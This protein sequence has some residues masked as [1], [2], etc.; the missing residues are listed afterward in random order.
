MKAAHRPA[1]GTA[2]DFLLS[3]A[4]AEIVAA[5]R[6]L[7]PLALL[8]SAALDLLPVGVYV[9][10]ADGYI[11]RANSAARRLW[12][13]DIGAPEPVQRFCGCFRL[14]TI[15]GKFIPPH[16]TPMARAIRDG[17]AFD[18]V[19]A[20][21]ENPDGRRWIAS[22]TVQPLRD[23][24]GR[25]LGAVN[26]FQDVTAQFERREAL[27]RQQKSVNL[28]MIASRMGTW[29]YTMADN[30]CLYDENAQQLYGLTS[31]RFLHDAQGVKEKFHPDDLEDMW[32]RVR[33]A[34]DPAGD[35]FYDVE[36][37]VKQLDGS[38][39]WL[40]AWG[41][42]EFEGEGDARKPVA[43]SGASRDISSLVEARE[44]QRLLVSELHHRV[45]N[46]FA[47]AGGLVTLSARTAVTPKELAHKVGERLGAL[48]RAHALTLPIQ[49]KEPV[50][51]SA[52]LQDL[53]A[54]IISP[55][56]GQTSAGK[57]RIAVSGIDM[58][59]T[60]QAVTSFALLLH[61]FATNAAKYGAL[62]V[63]AGHVEIAV[64]DA[65]GRLELTWRERGGPPVAEPVA[66]GFGS[67]LAR[68]TVTG[69]LNGQIAR[70]WLPEG[71]LIRLSIDR[72][73]LDQPL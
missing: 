71:L 13:R 45:K 38:W 18:N 31:P 69:Q 32:A 50:S 22:V 63:P 66:E 24:A 60:G 57:A 54:T 49:A 67:L 36:Y 26:C 52:M 73:R 7:E 6:R 28:A 47:L 53:I 25:L 72:T 43:I 59:I 1:Y 46:L 35:G 68:T 62:S 8:D 70:Q 55:F 3:H 44:A 56:E 15:G 21:V 42:V 14:Q 34:C 65:D 58:P 29:R 5:D 23:D 17:V 64:C 10:D 27:A 33:A 20:R 12:G 9:C 37:R 4:V 61:E 48:S 16:E 2:E 30:I 19:E 40:S 39:R 11:L 41:Y 51:Q